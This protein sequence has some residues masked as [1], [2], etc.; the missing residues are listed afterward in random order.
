MGEDHNSE[1]RSR[2][3]HN[4]RESLPVHPNKDSRSHSYS[5]SLDGLVQN[6]LTLTL[7][8]LERL[9]QYDLTDDF[10]CLEGWTVPEVRWSGVSLEDVLSL[11]EPLPE[12]QYVQASAGDF[13]LPLSLE[14]GGRALLAT[15]LGG[16]VLSV[17]HGGPVRLVIRGGQCFMQIKWLDRVEL[18][19]TADANTA[20]TIALG[21]LPAIASA[22]DK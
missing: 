2:L 6:R 7:K 11:A 14:E 4:I 19:R 1:E 20:K 12:A 17:E 3:G 21:R 13:S 9:P 18:R 15:H 5:L 10:T 8:D 22:S 16:E